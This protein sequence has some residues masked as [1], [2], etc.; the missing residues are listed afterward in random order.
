MLQA[1]PNNVTR[2][3]L[4]H[5]V[6]WV[7]GSSVAIALM[8]VALFD[9][10]RPAAV[11]GGSLLLVNWYLWRRGGPGRAWATKEDQPRT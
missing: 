6:L 7:I 9:D 2:F 1:R 11:G 10:W 5:P 4:S 3:A 8:G